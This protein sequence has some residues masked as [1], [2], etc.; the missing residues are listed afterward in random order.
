MRA[1]Q[2]GWV[3]RVQ[4]RRE[5]APSRGL[6]AGGGEPASP[7]KETCRAGKC[8]RTLPH[9][10]YLFRLDEKGPRVEFL[11]ACALGGAAQ[12]KVLRGSNENDRAPGR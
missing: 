1:P 7:D 10:A 6:R 3:R 8:T 4:A 2:Q 11:L 5:W 12:G 9:R